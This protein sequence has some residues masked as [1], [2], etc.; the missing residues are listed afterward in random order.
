M[1][2]PLRSWM[3][4]PGNRQR[5]LDKAIDE[6]EVDAIFMDIEDGV[7]PSEK[8]LARDQI[9]KALARPEGGPAR[10]VRVNAV[11]SDWF[12]DDMS[13]VLVPGIE[14]LCL[15]KVETA[16]EIREVASRLDAFETAAGVEPGSVRI[17]A[18]V[19]SAI[20]LLRAPETAAA[21]TR[22]LA[23][24]L[25]AEDYALDLGLA[26]KRVLE[27]RELIHARSCMVVAAASANVFAIDGVFPDLEDD[28]GFLADAEQARRLGFRGKSL[29][30]PKQIEHINRIFSPSED[31]IAYARKVVDAFD[32]ATARGD[33]AVAVGGQLVDLPIV[34]RAQR[35]LAL[36][37]SGVAS[38][39]E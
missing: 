16:E 17:V 20:G 9:A 21:S 28:E 11:G 32:E 36:V 31:D 34:L 38:G 8:A 13:T 23:L 12:E 5:F 37:E 15:P 6:L 3:F 24:M 18:A 26:A 1:E 35:L 29:F 19:E 25:G 2:R 4:V 22:L 39:G 7:P 14:G 10:F 27:A 30:H 33:G